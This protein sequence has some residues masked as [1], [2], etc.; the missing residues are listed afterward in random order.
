[1]KTNFHIFVSDILDFFY[2]NGLNIGISDG[3]TMQLDLYNNINSRKT[4]CQLYTWINNTN[5]NNNSE[6]LL[7]ANIHR[8]DAPIIEFVATFSDDYGD[9]LGFLV[10]PWS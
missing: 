1:M 5:N 2:F 4:V 10:Y 7:G 6:V 3:Q 8:P 9:H